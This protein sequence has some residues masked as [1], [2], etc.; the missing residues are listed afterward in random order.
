MHRQ[1]LTKTGLRSRFKTYSHPSAES[2][3]EDAVRAMTVLGSLTAA[4]AMV[5]ML[6]LL[7]QSCGKG[8][9]GCMS[10]AAG[11]TCFIACRLCYLSLF[12]VDMFY[13]LIYI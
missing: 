11:V 8:D 9:M 3:A 7:C 13:I 1:F 10:A 2:D 6:V 4:V 12:I 5:I